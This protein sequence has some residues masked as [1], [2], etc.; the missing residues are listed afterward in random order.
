MACSQFE[1]RILD[2][3]GMNRRPED[4]AE[5][6][7]HLGGCAPCQSFYD[8]QLSL[9]SFMASA[10]PAPKLRHGFKER[11][12]RRVAMEELQKQKPSLLPDILQFIGIVSVA[13]PAGVFLQMLSGVFGNTVL[14]AESAPL[15]IAYAAGAASLAAGMWT[16]FQDNLKAAF[17]KGFL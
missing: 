17:A 3:I 15:V 11:L 2:L 12:L 14:Q 10:I 9:D 4:D 8:E 7:K 1:E 13:I 5:L 16:A 6:A